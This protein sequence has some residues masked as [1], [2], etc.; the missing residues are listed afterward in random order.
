MRDEPVK[1]VSISLVIV[2]AN[3]AVAQERRPAFPEPPRLAITQQ[4]LDATKS[5]DGFVAKR[6]HAV[7]AAR[8]YLSNPIALPSGSGSWIFYY[9]CPNDGSAL[10]MLSLDEHECPSCKRRFADD[11]TA[12]AYRC[13]MH[14]D[15]ENAALKLAWAY[16]YAEDD[17][18][19][20]QV[21]RI[22]LHLADAYEHYPNRLDRWGRRGWLAPLGGRR[23]AQSLDEAVGVIRLAKAYDL[24]RRSAVWKP[25][26][27]THVEDDFF[28]ATAETLLRFNQGINNHQTWY[29]AGLMAIASVLADEKIVRKVLE[30]RGG[31]RDQLRRS[32]GDDGLWHE[33]TM[34]YQNYALQAMVEIVD[35][36]RRMGLALHEEPRFKLLLRSSLRVAYPN[37]KYPTVNDSDPSGFRNFNWSH[38]WAWRTYGDPVYAQAAAWGNRKLLT[39]LLGEDA[40]P[41]WPLATNSMNLSDAGLAILRVGEGAEQSCVF[42]DYGPHGGGHGH[43]DKLNITLFANGREW[44][45]DSGRIGY[46]HKEYKTWAKHTVAHNT[47]VIN[48]ASQWPATGTLNWLKIDDDWAACAGEC[49]TAYLGVSLR[50]YLLLTERMLVDVYEV[51]SARDV[52]VDW[53]AH[54]ASDPIKPVDQSAG[55]SVNSLG[56]ASGYQHLVDVRRWTA[57]A[58]SRWDFPVAS[59]RLRVWLATDE[60]E[61]IY[62][63]I[64][65]GSSAKQKAPVL[66]RRRADARNAR[67]VTVYDLSAE[68]RYIAGLK[69]AKGDLPKIDVKTTDGDWS[70]EFNRRDVVIASP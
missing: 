68:D 63:A 36:G 11:R 46:S 58:T 14:Y 45:L 29:N 48:G 2:L 42:F 61:E 13:R 7:K 35:A 55:E 47:V 4:E 28:R 38:R 15:L 27:R 39:E 18:Y 17:E 23:Y 57:K 6:D 1:S 54:A 24:T 65:I 51:R 49:Q 10:R 26:D 52:R 59:K 41:K 34:A 64:G 43:Y 30:M 32:L 19:A 22:L 69:Q 50:R 5:E 40:K 66:L 33:G 8:R 70:I 9:A 12:A 3:L 16:A 67:F 60:P 25:D 56:S 44:L 20:A 21:R 31:F 62:T 37:G 53:L